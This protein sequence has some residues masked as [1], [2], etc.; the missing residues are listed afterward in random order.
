MIDLL[1]SLVCALGIGGSLSTLC[2]FGSFDYLLPV[3]HQDKVLF[4]LFSSPPTDQLINVVVV[5]RDTTCWTRLN[6][7]RWNGGR[8]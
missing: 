2:D 1:R 7:G 5:A 8:C 4:V 6:W 3:A